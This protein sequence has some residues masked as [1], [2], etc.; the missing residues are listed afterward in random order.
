[1]TLT[2]TPPARRTRGPWPA[3]TLV[4]HL[5]WSAVGLVVLYLVSISLNQFQD[6]QLA[7][8]CY[9]AIAAAG[10]TVLSGLSGQIS[11]GNG[12]FMAVGD[13]KSVV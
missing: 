11:L 6:L 4:R 8:I 10:L 12:A 2:E 13:R 5:L 7:Q 3:S 1:M 9:T